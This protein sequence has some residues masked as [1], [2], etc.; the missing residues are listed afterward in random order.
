MRVNNFLMICG[1]LPGYAAGQCNFTWIDY[2][3]GSCTEGFLQLY[4]TGVDSVVWSNGQVGFEAHLP[5][6]TYDWQAYQ[7]G[8]VVQTF[9]FEMKQLGWGL[10]LSAS[11]WQGGGFAI[12]GWGEVG[13]YSDTGFVQGAY[14]DVSAYHGPCCNPVDSLTHVRLVQDGA[15]ELDP[16]NC[17]GCDSLP[18]YGHMV[19]FGNVP[20]GHSYHLRLHDLACGQV[21]DD[22]TQV[23]AHAC[24]N[25]GLSIEAV[26]TPPGA[27]EGEVHLLEAV[28]DTTEPYPLHAPVAGS[29]A[30]YR[31][32]DGWDPAGTTYNSV[33]TASW[34][35][36]DTG[37][38][39]VVFTPDAGCNQVTDTVLV[40]L[41]SGV[42][43]N[44][45]QAALQV[46]RTNAPDRIMVHVRGG[47]AARVRLFNATGQEVPVRKVE[48]DLYDIGAVPPGVYLVKVDVGDAVLSAKFL[49]P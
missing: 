29:A 13:E 3:F 15:V 7:D 18:C 1:L 19:W 42:V 12:S 20:T 25:L 48:G 37:F 16:V 38:Y 26:G 11:Y 40:S 46:V 24:D 32:L 17:M 45:P 23:I 10:S 4:C 9:P 22:S 36:L 8:Q 28:P 49:Q 39:R 33:A 31:G 41:P 30:I 34:T 43:E 27:M 5:T 35:G 6:G 21:V 2:P 47:V 44:G 14:C